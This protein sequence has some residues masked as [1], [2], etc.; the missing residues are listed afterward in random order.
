MIRRHP[1]THSKMLPMGTVTSISIAVVLFFA[2]CTG[3][4]GETERELAELTIDPARAE[5]AIGEHAQ[6]EAVGVLENGDVVEVSPEWAHSGDL[7]SF[8][9]N[10]EFEAERI[11]DGQVVARVD[12]VEAVAEIVVTAAPPSELTLGSESGEVRA[13][14]ET[15]VTITVVDEHGNP[16]PD[17]EVELSV[18]PDTATLEPARGETSSD[19]TFTA[20]LAFEGKTG[21][22]T[23]TATANDL[24]D[25]I[26]I[27]GVPGA[28][29]Q[30]SLTAD[31]SPVLAGSSTT[32]RAT[33]TDSFDNPV[34]ET[35][36]RFSL[37]TP[38]GSLSE[39]SVS[40]GEDG[41]ASVVLTAAGE[42]RDNVVEAAAAELPAK[43]LEV[44]GGRLSRLVISPADAEV[45]S[46]KTKS[47]AARGFDE[48]GTEVP[49]D[50][51]WGVRGEIGRIDDAGTLTA[52]RTGEGSVVATLRNVTATASVSVAPG[53]LTTIAIAPE[54]TRITAGETIRLEAKGLD[55]AG[56]EIAI[57]PEWSFTD[58][59][60]A[61]TL[62][63][64]GTF[65][66]ETTG[67]FEVQA[68][69]DDV[70]ATANL[71]VTP[72]ALTDIR[73]SPDEIR[74]EAG[75]EQSF[76]ATGYDVY[77]N[78]IEVE[79]RWTVD[80][81]IG[82][83]DESGRFRAVKAGDGELVATSGRRA[84]RASIEV[85]PSELAEI[86]VEPETSEVVSG[87]T[88][89][90]T[91]AGRDAFGNQVEVSPEWSV[92]GEIGTIDDH[93]RFTAV[94]AG[95][96]TVVARS[97]AIAGDRP[98]RVVPGAL[99]SIELSP[100]EAEMAAGSSE[101]FRAVGFDAAG[102]ESE[103]SPDWGVT[104]DVGDISP[105]GR[106]QA[107][108]AGRGRVVAQ[109]GSITQEASVRVRPGKL[110][111]IE[112]EPA[113][114]D[115][116]A[117]NHTSFS[118]TGQDAHGNEIEI[119]PSWTIT[120]GIGEI[121]AETGRFTAATVGQG[122]VV[123]TVGG[124]GGKAD[125][126]VEA[127]PLA[128]I[129]ISPAVPLTAG[130]THRFSASGFDAAGNPVSIHPEWS[131][132][133]DFG[134]IG[135]QGELIAVKAGKGKVAA[136][137]NGV[138]GRV[139]VDV[140]PGPLAWLEL[141]P[142]EATLRSTETKKFHVVAKDHFGNKVAV[143]P[144]WNVRTG[145]GHVSSDGTF[146]ATATGTGKIVVRTESLS[147]SAD[148]TVEPGP[149]VAIRVT[150]ESTEIRAGSKLKFDA[151]GRDAHGNRTE[152]EP[153]WSVTADIGTIDENGLFT[154][155]SA[156]SGKVLAVLPGVVG[157]ANVTAVPG[158]VAKLSVSA[159]RDR[160]RSGDT[161][162]LDVVGFDAHGNRI[163]SPEVTWS[164]EHGFGTI[165]SG[166]GLFTAVRAGSGT[167]AAEHGS[168]R[169][170][171]GLNVVP[172]EPSPTTS[173]VRLD[174]ESVAANEDASIVV[175]VD[176][177]D[178]FRNP[179]P[180]AVVELRTSRPDEDTIHP[181]E[182]QTG[183][184]GAVRFR[185]TSSAPGT[186]TLEV[187]AD[188]VALTRNTRLRFHDGAE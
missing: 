58:D 90:F 167:V 122:N 45:R 49:V 126:T 61:G 6:F 146:T 17:T 73:I 34:P 69:V 181:D 136:E 158:D 128:R 10:G 48:A 85:V 55:A 140:R 147:A 18:E 127:G 150:P 32:I 176:V 117:G 159:E 94:V 25:S 30:I 132:D 124:V 121:D 104:G 93:G 112:V 19:G 113:S 37:A 130:E 139:T 107:K 115:V 66:T 75:S 89:H 108:V 170:T 155:A 166:S 22:L 95:R 99:T 28:P 103:L 133:G 157:S 62:D 144:E 14:S 52:V 185:V 79:P 91:A 39:S 172:G 114:F 2:G 129:E 38:G 145:I 142:S 143:D 68:K 96:G 92:T 173:S 80:G 110:V 3:N 88:T 174:P 161:L 59:A 12:G 8:G 23:V 182:T 41:R 101:T 77:G 42:V 120:G 97:D 171:L 46:G 177:R 7:G 175:Q 156:G 137:A 72:G 43:T 1:P 154:A 36:V 47:F 188:G 187:L 186:S 24:T 179:I 82:T 70:T 26:T 83:V 178:Q 162:S 40:T 180:G 152:V 67:R 118:A 123:A 135:P 44:H 169:A 105:D 102:N 116:A 27:D 151:E 4:G 50:A 71:E 163:E 119:D 109:R 78:E 111:E 11:G 141:S 9:E 160:V 21:V 60:L 16:V 138:T 33:V 20:A 56:N 84:G 100:T 125:V 134:R 29:A 183:D 87:T 148:V 54:S 98:V 81:D 63:P 31:P 106:F 153:S 164:V 13:G 51:K 35:E 149:T 131:V 5:I 15:P 74:A 168:V 86:W 184:D 53:E 65:R 57:E 165:D 64:E 76:Q